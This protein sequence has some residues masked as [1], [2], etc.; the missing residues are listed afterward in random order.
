MDDPPCYVS[1]CPRYP[2]ISCQTAPSGGF[3][4]LLALP[5][6]RGLFNK[7]VVAVLILVCYYRAVYTHTHTG[8]YIQEFTH[9]L[10][11]NLCYGFRAQLKILTL[12]YLWNV[13]VKMFLIQKRTNLD[14]ILIIHHLSQKKASIYKGEN[15]KVTVLKD[16]HTVGIF[17]QHSLPH[18]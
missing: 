15:I 9:S 18:L 16:L 6:T 4:S 13:D 12:N 1:H 2:I 8:L 10:L 3:G 7:K 11:K 5:N 14:I 17:T